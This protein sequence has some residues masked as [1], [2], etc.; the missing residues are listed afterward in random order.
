MTVN[1]ASGRNGNLVSPREPVGPPVKAPEATTVSPLAT[2]KVPT[3]AFIETG[4]AVLMVPVPVNCRVPAA[5]K[6]IVPSEELP[7]PSAASEATADHRVR[8]PIRPAVD[9]LNLAVA[10]GIALHRLTWL[11]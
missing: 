3:T 4:R 7:V 9:S 10:A 8:I 6:R 11:T 1:R 2:S 5:L